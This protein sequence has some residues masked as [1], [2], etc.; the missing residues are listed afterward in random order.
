MMYTVSISSNQ[1]AGGNVNMNVP[2]E[3]T[4]VLDALDKARAQLAET[5]K[6]SGLAI[7]VAAQKA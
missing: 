4:D 6:A 5:I 3:A 2:V 1:A 7:A